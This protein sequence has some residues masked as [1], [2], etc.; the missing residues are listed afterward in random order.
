MIALAS[1]ATRHAQPTAV[2]DSAGETFA[3]AL[4]VVCVSIQGSGK[5]PVPH[6]HPARLLQGY[7]LRWA[8]QAGISIR[9][10]RE[11]RDAHF[12]IAGVSRQSSHSVAGASPSPWLPHWW[13]RGR[14]GDPLPGDVVAGRASPVA[15]HPHM[16]SPC[17]VGV[18]SQPGMP[19][20]HQ[21]PSEPCSWPTL[22]PQGWLPRC[23]TGHPALA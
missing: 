11:S 17:P 18:P 21:L 16:L 6:H 12:C 7:I 4:A 2:I 19:H 23:S 15:G 14:P 5:K 9:R 22:H 20:A 13:H 1:S 10:R 3:L 8:L